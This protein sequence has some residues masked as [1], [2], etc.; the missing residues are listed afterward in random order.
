MDKKDFRIENLS[1]PAAVRGLNFPLF[2]L[3]FL[4]G[5]FL[6][7]DPGSVS[8]EPLAAAAAAALKQRVAPQNSAALATLRCCVFSCRAAISAL[9]SLIVCS[10]TLEQLQGNNKII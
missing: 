5:G 3:F 7:H 8:L 4:G 1:D 2:P 9:L 6:Q 10:L